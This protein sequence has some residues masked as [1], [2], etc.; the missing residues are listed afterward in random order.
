MHTPTIEQLKACA[1]SARLRFKE[2]RSFATHHVSFSAEEALEYAAELW[3]I[4]HFG[5]EG[6]CD[7]CGRHG[8]TYLNMGDTYSTT[9]LFY[10]ESSTFRI[11][12]WGDI[13]E[14]H[15]ARYN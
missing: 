10:S 15:P 2:L 9:I 13:V 8:I 4:D 3:G 7:D 14:R 5:V 6:F 1:K 12:T 11:G